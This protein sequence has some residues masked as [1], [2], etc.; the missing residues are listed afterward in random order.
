MEDIEAVYRALDVY[1]FP[2][3]AEGLGSSLLS[4]MSYSL[5]VVAVA[6]CAVPEVIRDGGNGLLVPEPEPG[7]IARAIFRFL[8]D[9]ALAK[10]LG[11]AARQ[12]IMQSFSVG[13][14]VD[15]TL[16]LYQRIVAEPERT[17]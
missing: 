13:R 12:T 16:G 10:K 7:A 5:P 3:Q 4:A 6:E 2:S 17:A 9:S 1:V 14:L 8:D 15:E 11:D